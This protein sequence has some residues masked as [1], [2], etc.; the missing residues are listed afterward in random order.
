MATINGTNYNDNG[1]FQGTYPYL[2]FYPILT[3]TSVADTIY[4]YGG[5]DILDG[6][7]G[8]D[9]MYGGTGND[10]YYVDNIDDIVAENFNEGI[11]TVYAS[12]SYSLRNN[13]ENLSLTGTGVINGYGNSLNNVING[14]S[15]NNIIYGYGGNDT[16]NGGAGADIMYGGAGND[17]YY[18]DHI[19]D[20]VAENFG[21]GIDTV[22]ASVNYLLRSYSSSL[23]LTMRSD[24]ENIILT[25]TSHL[26]AEGSSVDNTII[27]NSGNNLLYGYGGNDTIY[28]RDGDDSIYAGPGGGYIYGENGNDQLLGG[29]DIDTLFGGAGDDLLLGNGGNDVLYGGAGADYFYFIYLSAGIDIIMDFESSEKDKILIDQVG[30]GASSLSQFT[31]DSS[32]GDLFFKS[33]QFATIVNNPLGFNILSDLV[34]L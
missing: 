16:I 31:Y 23:D 2:I 33:T 13:V 7:A 24:P 32:T 10:S 4:G 25:G 28:G 11:D 19:D 29:D 9:T 1:T 26:I 14:N 22:Y 27:G 6:G 15:A 20:I 5:N 8:V 17:I 21:E 12:V 34:L 30:F 18:V 3:G